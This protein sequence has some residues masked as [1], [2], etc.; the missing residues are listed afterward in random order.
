[1]ATQQKASPTPGEQLNLIE[2]GPENLAKIKPVALEYRQIMQQRVQMTA[3]EVAAKQG[4][5]ELVHEA[6]LKPNDQGIIKFTCDGLVI[7]VTPR[8]ELIQVKDG[9]KKRGRPKK[10][11]AGKDAA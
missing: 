11:R 2:V 3:Q 8:D 6:K 5:L 10:Q 9:T 7:S 1:M 4:L